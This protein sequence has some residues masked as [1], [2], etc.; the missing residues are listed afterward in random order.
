L[1]GVLDNFNRSNGGIGAGWSGATSG[2]SIAS[3]KLDVGNGGDI[4]WNANAFGASQEAYI[5]FSTVASSGE[6][7]DLILKSQCNYSYTCGVLEV[8]YDAVNHVIKVATYESSQGWVQHGADITSITF[9]NGDV[10]GARATVNGQVS[11]YKNGSLLGTRDISSWP[12]Y[13][14]GGYIGLWCVNAGNALLDDFGGGT[15]PGSSLVGVH[16]KASLV[17]AAHEEKEY[18]KAQTML[19]PPSGQVWRS[20]YFQGATRLAM[21]VQV[22]G[23]TDQVYYLLTDHLGSTTVSYRSDG[24]DTR[25]QSYKPWGEMRQGGNS[26]PTDRTFT[27]QRWEE[28]GLYYFNARWYDGALGR[29][30]QADT[31]IPNPF[32]ATAY[33][34]YAYV[35]NSVMRFTDPTG[36][37]CSEAGE[38]YQPK[39]LRP[40]VKFTAEEGQ[41]WEKEQETVLDAANDVGAGISRTINRENWELWKNGDLSSYPSHISARQAFLMTFGGPVTFH[42]VNAKGKDGAWGEVQF[43]T[44]TINVFS[45]AS[46]SQIISH[47]RWAVH[48]MGHAFENRMYQIM[49]NRPARNAVPVELLV[50]EPDYGGFHSSYGNWQFNRDRKAGEIFADMFVGWVYNSWEVNPLGGPTDLAILRSQNMSY[51]MP[52]WVSLCVGR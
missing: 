9:A 3:N 42:R 15:M 50:R 11:V 20:Y 37:R 24:V 47:P 21:R 46:A 40:L 5:K 39:P 28:V 38:C 10:F 2:Y 17:K 14:D 48:E 13:D 19:A 44:T 52:I 8:W 18:R 41:E 35:Y 26:L 7:Q 31:V 30:A 32:F 34:R 6:E 29:F 16:V 23:V 1:T 43:G 36:H 49:N 25:F 12:Y 33:D 4:Y 27:G 22:N 51:Y 45:N